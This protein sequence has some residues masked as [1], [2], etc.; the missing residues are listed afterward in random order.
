MAMA[1]LARFRRARP[2]VI[3]AKAGIHCV[4]RSL[5]KVGGVDSRLRG[6]DVWCGTLLLRCDTPAIC[7]IIQD[8]TH[9]AGSQ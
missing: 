2:R 6:N 5:L 3:P 4:R 1:S 7:G 9:D 8:W